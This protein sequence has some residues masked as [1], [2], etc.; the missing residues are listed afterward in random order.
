MKDMHE[1]T[2]KDDERGATIVRIRL[3]K[4]G[5]GIDKNCRYTPVLEGRD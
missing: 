3:E 2:G 4:S 5:K 1:E